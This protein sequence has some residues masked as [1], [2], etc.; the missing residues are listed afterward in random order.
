MHDNKSDEHGASGVLDPDGRIDPHAP[1][2][3]A[4][5]RSADAVRGLHARLLSADLTLL[6]ARSVA[7]MSAHLAVFTVAERICRSLRFS[8]GVAIQPT[9]ATALIAASY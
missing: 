1:A 3:I 7:T 5:G 2:L 9:A 8:A 4:L 6:G